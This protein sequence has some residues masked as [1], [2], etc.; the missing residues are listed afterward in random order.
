MIAS[1]L[2][3]LELPLIA[4]NLLENRDKVIQYLRDNNWTV[5]DMTSQW[6][7]DECNDHCYGKQTDNRL[8][9]T[10]EWGDT[11]YGKQTD[12]RL[13]NTK[14]VEIHPNHDRVIIEWLYCVLYMMWCIH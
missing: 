8:R 11:C 6:F 7:I 9:F 5:N 10:N 12:I 14:G 13:R 3:E 4:A 2:R 1:K